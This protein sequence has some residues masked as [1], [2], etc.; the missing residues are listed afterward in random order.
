MGQQPQRVIEDPVFDEAL[1]EAL[2]PPGAIIGERIV[3][4]KV[5]N[6]PVA[7]RNASFKVRA[8]EEDAPIEERVNGDRGGLARF[9]DGD[10]GAAF[11][12]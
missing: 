7:C 9:F 8:L 4:G 1:R 5:G 10:D 3:G 11:Q 12:Q 2:G 6:D